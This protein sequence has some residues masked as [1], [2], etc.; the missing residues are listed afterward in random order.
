MNDPGMLQRELL[1]WELP[2]L[3]ALLGLM[4]GS[5]LNVVVYRL[6][7]ML[8][9]SWRRDCEQF[10][11]LKPSFS[12]DRPYNLVWPRSHCV[13]CGSMIPWWNNLPIISYALLRGKCGICKAPISWRYPLLELLTAV[14][15]AVVVWR[16]GLTLQAVSGLFLTW[17]LMVLAAIDLEKQLLPDCLTLP[18]LWLGLLLSLFNVYTDSHSSIMGAATGYL[19]LWL[20]YWLFKWVTGKDGMGYG[21][22]K[23]LALLGAWLGWTALPW[24]ILMS[25]LSGAV[26]GG[27]LMLVG[28]HQRGQAIPFG[29]F[30]ALAGWITLIWGA[31]YDLLIGG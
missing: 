7:R 30:I 27:L 13:H 4:V 2:A 23:L 11:E 26:V 25:S 22:F 24:V 10:L 29:P 1:S 19:S 28:R 15:S 17:S 18:T 12:D 8:E 16:F 3:A 6:P 9:R 21:D 20:I 14:L 5:F 31:S